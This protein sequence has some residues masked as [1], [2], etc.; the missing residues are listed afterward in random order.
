LGRHLLLDHLMRQEG[1]ERM[2]RKLVTPHARFV[3]PFREGYDIPSVT[4]TTAS[5]RCWSCGGFGRTPAFARRSGLGGYEI[6][7]LGQVHHN[8]P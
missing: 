6:A 3:S 2:R 7:G 8:G 4:A 5:R 1:V